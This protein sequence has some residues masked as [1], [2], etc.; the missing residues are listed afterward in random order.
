MLGAF[1]GPI[2]TKLFGGLSLIL[3]IALGIQTVRL[4]SAHSSIERLK[5]DLAGVTAQRDAFRQAGEIMVAEGK[6]RQDRATEALRA[7][8]RQSRA[9]AGQISRIRNAQPSTG[10]ETPKEVRDAAGL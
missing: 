5:V 1:F 2:G 4:S 6:A 7:Q 8:E 3:L 10:C 9:I